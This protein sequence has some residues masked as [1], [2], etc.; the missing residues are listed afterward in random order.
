MV[1]F[2]LNPTWRESEQ[3]LLNQKIIIYIPTTQIGYN[4]TDTQIITIEV[5]YLTKH[6]AMMKK[7]SDPDL[8]SE[9]I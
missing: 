6:V 9:K 5:E 4:W 8:Q 3:M 1:I 2:P 7:G